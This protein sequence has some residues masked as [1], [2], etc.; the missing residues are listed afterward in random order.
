VVRSG[1]SALSAHNAGL[2]EGDE[3][4]CYVRAEDLSE[5]CLKYALR[6]DVDRHRTNVI[7]HVVDAAPQAAEWLFERPVA[8]APVVA[9]DLADRPQARERDA[10]RKL[11]ASSG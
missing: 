2:A 1:V 11:M 8:P 4:E 7:L 3:V 9:A 6:P 5:L 10:A